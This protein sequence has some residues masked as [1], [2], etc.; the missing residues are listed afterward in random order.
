VGRAPEQTEEYINE[1]IQPVLDKNEE[2]LG[3]KAEI[4]V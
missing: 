3:I 2:I 4:N 1:Y